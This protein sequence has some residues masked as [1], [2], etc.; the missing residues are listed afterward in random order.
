[1]PC[2][3]DSSRNLIS[4]VLFIQPCLSTEEGVR[5]GWGSQIADKGRHLIQVLPSTDVLYVFLPSTF[6]YCFSIML[7]GAVTSE[8]RLPGFLKISRV[9][10]LDLFPMF[11]RHLP[12]L[13]SS[14]RGHCDRRQLEPVNNFLLIVLAIS[15][16]PRRRSAT[17]Q[18]LVPGL[19]PGY[20][21]TAAWQCLGSYWGPHR[22]PL[23]LSNRE[24]PEIT[25]THLSPGLVLL[26]I[27]AA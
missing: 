8:E 13:G 17:L 2:W 10:Y 23:Q 6:H 15:N 12:S 16:L 18:S 19:H 5:C 3:G 27:C 9:P 21:P 24:H 11:R 7:A 14:T 20:L 22:E 25:S 26:W 1:M 4:F